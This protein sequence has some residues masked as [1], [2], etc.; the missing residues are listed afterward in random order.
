MV[1]RMAVERGL[2]VPSLVALID[3]EARKDQFRQFL[4]DHPD[5]W[6]WEGGITVHGDMH[7]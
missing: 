3:E 4:R 1:I 6:D 7:G 2:V 5:G